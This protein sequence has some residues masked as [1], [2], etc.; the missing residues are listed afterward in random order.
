MA[1]SG[2]ASPKEMVAVL[3]QP[4]AAGAI[5]SISV[6]REALPDPIKLKAPDAI[7][8]DGKVVLPWSSVR[9]SAAKP[10]SMS[11][12]SVFRLRTQGPFR[13]DQGLPAALGRA[14]ENWAAM[15]KRR[16]QDASR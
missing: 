4:P 11:R 10:G 8:A 13:C 6:H 16:R 2:A 9:R 12:L 15:A 14:V 1:A 7:K 3:M 5:L